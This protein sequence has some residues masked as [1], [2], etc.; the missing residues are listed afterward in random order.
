MDN[1]S[2]LVIECATG[3]CGP[4]IDAIQQIRGS[5]VG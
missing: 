1:V 2:F 4:G 3:A 5:T